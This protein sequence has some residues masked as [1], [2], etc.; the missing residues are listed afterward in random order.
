[1]ITQSQ[2]LAQ[3]VTE[4]LLEDERTSESGIEVINQR[5]LVT[6]AGSVKNEAIR[7]AAEQLARQ[8]AGVVTV[9][10]ELKIA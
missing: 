4:A 2:D 9:V 5:G 1:M 10:N 8:Q 7:Q 6:L 3:R